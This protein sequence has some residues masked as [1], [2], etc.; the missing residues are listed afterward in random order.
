MLLTSGPQNWINQYLRS[1]TY[2]DIDPC[3]AH[4]HNLY[5]PNHPALLSPP[6][7]WTSVLCKIPAWETIYH[8]VWRRDLPALMSQAIAKNFAH[9]RSRDLELKWLRS[10]RITKYCIKSCELCLS[11][12]LNRLTL[13]SS[14]HN[15]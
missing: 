12:I 7:S 8:I 15:N 13:F 3:S 4:V 6:P 11:T 2:L 9:S 1:I 5:G 10:N 14:F